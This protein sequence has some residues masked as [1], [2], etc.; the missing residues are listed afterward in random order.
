MAN[1]P[2]VVPRGQPQP[3]LQSAQIN[4]RSEVEITRAD[5]SRAINEATTS[6]K[7]FINARS[8]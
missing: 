7:N 2:K 4:S 5:L 3:L 1:E 8:E 6:V